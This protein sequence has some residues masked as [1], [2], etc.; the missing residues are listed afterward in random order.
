VL[1]LISTEANADLAPAGPLR[2]TEETSA[3]T[4]LGAVDDAGD[5]AILAE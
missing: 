3:R 4:L 1:A 2:R 5:I